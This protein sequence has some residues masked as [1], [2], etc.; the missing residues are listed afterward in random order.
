MAGYIPPG[1]PPGAP[2]FGAP[3]GGAPPYGAPPGGAPP[4]GAPPGGAPPYGA[5]P[6][7]APGF[8]GP[9]GGGP[10]D[11]EAHVKKWFTLSIVSFFCG[12]GILALIPIMM[13]S[14]AKDALSK[15]DVATAQQKIGT[16]RMLVL[17]GFG[18]M[19][20]EVVG[21]I[22]FGILMATGVINEGAF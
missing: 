16:A 3:P 1:G 20:L 13:A 14:S 5:P 19:A 22:I 4:Y 21:A 2:P 12:C 6:G 15:G 10:P 11:L 18:L 9:P 17:I 8:G 7:G